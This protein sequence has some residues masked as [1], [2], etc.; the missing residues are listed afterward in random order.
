MG[1]KQEYE[2]K[3]KIEATRVIRNKSVYTTLL[4]VNRYLNRRSSEQNENTPQYKIDNPLKI[5]RVRTSFSF[6]T[7]IYIYIYD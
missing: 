1:G 4:L 6:K 5:T 2:H 3:N 7:L